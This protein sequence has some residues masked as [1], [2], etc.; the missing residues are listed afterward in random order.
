MIRC[1]QASVTWIIVFQKRIICSE[2]YNWTSFSANVTFYSS[3]C[4]IRPTDASS[5]F[6]WRKELSKFSINQLIC[7]R[8]GLNGSVVKEKSRRSRVLYNDIIRFSSA[9]K[10]EEILKII[11]YARY[12]SLLITLLFQNTEFLKVD[13][14][15]IFLYTIQWWTCNLWNGETELFVEFDLLCAIFNLYYIFY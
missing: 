11:Q 6:R 1:Y 3:Y 2:I 10:A 4:V 8:W 15:D 13:W 5:W 14:G 7:T 12:F 9:A